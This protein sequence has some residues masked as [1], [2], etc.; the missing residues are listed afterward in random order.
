MVEGFEVERELFVA[1]QKDGHQLVQ[2]FNAGLDKIKKS[3][4]FE[5]IF[6]GYGLESLYV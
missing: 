6:I 4:L 2:E 3:G 5:R 1:F